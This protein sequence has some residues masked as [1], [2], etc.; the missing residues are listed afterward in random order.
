M[1]DKI[2]SGLVIMSRVKGTEIVNVLGR[3]LNLD[4]VG[5]RY[6]SILGLRITGKPFD[7][8]LLVKVVSG[9]KS[10]EMLLQELHN[11]LANQMANSPV[12]AAQETRALGPW[13]N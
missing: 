3:G 10:L 11:A 9:V 2:E 6:A 13:P 8:P 5:H 7:P 1:I 12:G 4:S